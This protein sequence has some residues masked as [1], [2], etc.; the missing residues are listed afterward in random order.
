MSLP[1]DASKS[2]QVTVDIKDRSVCVG[3]MMSTSWGRI[4][5]FKYGAFL[6]MLNGGRLRC[7]YLLAWIEQSTKTL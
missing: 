3:L 4:N 7:K 6:V 2:K 1:K 5:K